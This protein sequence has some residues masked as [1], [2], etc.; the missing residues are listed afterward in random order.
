YNTPL[1]S[2]AVAD[3]VFGQGGSFTTNTCNLGGLST[4]SLCVPQGVA[5]DAASNLYVAD[6]GSLRLLEYDSPLTT[7]AVADRVVSEASE[8]VSVDAAGN[9]YV[10][11]RGGG[12]MLE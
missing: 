11:V 5:L 2:D 9:L 8:G 1:T 6:T 10:S 3:R 4:S 7:D 12:Q